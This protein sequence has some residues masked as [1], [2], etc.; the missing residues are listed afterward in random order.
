MKRSDWQY[1]IDSLL[2]ITIIGIVFIGFLLGL[3]LPE[4]PSVSESSKY[5]LRIHRHDW[6]HIHFYLSIAFT[7]L[8]IIHLFL[9][10]RWIKG[11]AKQIFKNSWSTLLILT[12]VIAVA[13][14]LFFWSLW[15]KYSQVYAEYGLGPRKNSAPLSLYR[16]DARQALGNPL[17]QRE[18][19][20]LLVT[21]QTTLADLEKSTGISSDVIIEQLGLPKRTKPNETL[22]RLRKRFGFELQDV[23]DIITSLLS[24]PPETIPDQE[25]KIPIPVP[26]EPKQESVT[27]PKP[28]AKEEQHQEEQHQEEEKITRGRMAE[29]QSGI[30]ITGQM[31][32]R[33]IEAQTGIPARNIIAK[34]GLPSTL[35]TTERLGR[36][37][38]MYPFTLQ[39]VRDA[40][41]ALLKETKIEDSI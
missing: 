14:P 34:L 20:Y 9:S 26:A 16:E 39:S 10:W 25:I 18:E 22:G 21:G 41:A 37:R 15:P 32:F 2:F 1:L 28:K 7:T 33:D 11:K 6:G 30:L 24:V 38:K 12:L 23:R 29:D 31:T 36:L 35:P 19:N 5:F 4:G 3:V 27:A 17:D 13:T 40:V 8:L